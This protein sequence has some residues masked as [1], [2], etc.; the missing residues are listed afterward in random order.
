ML[1][2]RLSSHHVRVAPDLWSIMTAFALIEGPAAFGFCR[3][4]FG[5]GRFGM[6]FL[7]VFCCLLVFCFG[8]VNCFVLGCLVLS[9]LGLFFGMLFFAFFAVFF[10]GF[11]FW[12]CFFFDLFGCFRFFAV[13]FSK[14][15]KL[16]KLRPCQKESWN[17]VFFQQPGFA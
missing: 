3:T 8:V 9:T 12:R 14:E 11:G 6:F 16:W 17:W 5:W 1:M 2:S 13:C 7:C 4:V 10:F 15:Q